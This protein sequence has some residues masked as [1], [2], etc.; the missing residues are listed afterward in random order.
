MSV[1]ER[2][3]IVVGGGIAGM[4]AAIYAAR[5]GLDLL[6]FEKAA[7]GGVANASCSV[8]NFPSYEAIGGIE[9]MQRIRNHVRSLGVR[10]EELVEVEQVDLES[11]TNT[12]TTA[13][14]R[15]AAKTLI[16]ATGSVPNHLPIEGACDERVH[17]CALCDGP[18]YKGKDVVVVGGGNTGFDESLYLLTLGVRSVVLVECLDSCG[19]AQV[20]QQ[21]A[22][23]TGRIAVRTSCRVRALVLDGVRVLVDVQDV[24]TGASDALITDGVFVYMGY[25]PNSA[26]VAGQL[27]LDPSGCVVADALMHTSRPGVFAAGDIIAK[28]YRQLTTA[29]ADGTIAALEAARYVRE[30]A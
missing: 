30:H 14:A 28:R 25:A 29:M 22:R 15:H 11:G 24:R 16:I 5:A 4:T 7:C 12:I 23:S 10:I 1:P 18:A 26:L 27:D 20:I 13:D 21:R 8:E 17:Y 6:L 2:D 9:L 19:A 3:L